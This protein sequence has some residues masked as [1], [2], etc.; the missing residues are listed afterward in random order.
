MPG[1]GF[2][3]IV[4]LPQEHISWL[5]AQ[6]DNILSAR[7]PQESRIAIQYTMPTIDFSHD[8]FQVDIRKVLTPNLGK[9][10]EMIFLNMRE[11]IDKVMGTKSDSWRDVNLFKTMEGIMFS[12]LNRI[13]VGQPL[14]SDEGYLNS[15]SNLLTW[16]GGSGLVVGQLMPPFLKPVTGYLTAIPIHI[17]K[18]RA[19]SFLRPVIQ[20]QRVSYQRKVKEPSFDVEESD[21][22]LSW[23][24]A[25]SVDGRDTRDLNNDAIAINILFMVSV[26]IGFPSSNS[27]CIPRTCH[28]LFPWAVLIFRQSLAGIFP[29]ILTATNNF[30][31]IL[32]SDPSLHIY[33]KLHKEAAAVFKTDRDWTDYTL[34]AKLVLADSAIRETLRQSP[35]LSRGL[36][37]EVVP[38]NGI[39]LPSGHRL[40]RGTWVAIALDQIHR[41]GRFYENPEQ[42][43]AF[44]FARED[45]QS[46]GDFTFKVDAEKASASQKRHGFTTASDTY[47][48]WGYGRHTW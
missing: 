3:P 7:I 33:E 45:T 23:M 12:S 46:S 9:L 40:P 17:L 47:L 36:V 24:V 16:L 30:L 8:M 39:D 32:T 4:T 5:I 38:K 37:R 20:A 6:P 35:L 42:Y 2:G 15:L 44:R 19:L 1:L 29:T 28:R 11:S 43:D 13:A 14:C 26:L 18:R 22:L 41:D 27:E 21:N 31:D 25:A 34:M 10:Q 48:P